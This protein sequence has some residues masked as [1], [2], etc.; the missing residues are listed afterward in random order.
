ML[1]D[2]LRLRGHDVWLDEWEIGLGDS[3]IG[4][5]D[6]GLDAATYVVLCYSSSG[7]HSPWMGRE[8]MSALARQLSGA[9]VKLLPVVL[10]GGGPPAVMADIKYVDL[11]ADWNRGIDR[12]S[13]A[14]V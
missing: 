5:M 11:S 3:V 13:A 10:T 8:W 6:S 14:I 9:N 1:A 2:E 7:V 12:L 4:E